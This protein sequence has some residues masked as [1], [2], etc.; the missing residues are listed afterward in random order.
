MM[1]G[2]VKETAVSKPVVLDVLVVVFFNCYM[3]HSL[4]CIDS[5]TELVISFIHKK[6]EYYFTG[7]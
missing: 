4:L 2:H 7:D 3:G 5:N 6:A 1:K